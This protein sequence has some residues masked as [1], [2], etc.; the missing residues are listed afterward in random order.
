MNV[1]LPYKSPLETARCLDKRRLNKQIIECEQI[2]NAINGVSDAWKNHPIVRMYKDHLYFLHC[3]TEILKMYKAEGYSQVSSFD[4]RE[5][6]IDIMKI[7][8]DF[9]TDE[10]CDNM[11]KRLFTKDPEH[12]KQFKPYGKSYV[13]MYFVEGE[14]KYYLQKH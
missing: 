7:M 12:Y 9:I 8:P 10:Y 13:N 5:R 14:W 1:F 3:Y 2:A 6:S 4:L 11:K